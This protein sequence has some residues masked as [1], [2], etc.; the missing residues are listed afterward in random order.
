ML[1]EVITYAFQI[2]AGLKTLLDQDGDS[3]S[4]NQGDCDDT[5]NM[6]N[7][8]ALDFC[9]DG[10]DQDCNGSDLECLPRNNFV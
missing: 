2:E 6:I 1:Y 4:V 9:G 10:I 5:N 3:F 8:N 7:P